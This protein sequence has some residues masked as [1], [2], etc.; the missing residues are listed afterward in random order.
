MVVSVASIDV[1]GPPRSVDAKP[2]L[3]ALLALVG[4]I[5]SFAIVAELS[6]SPISCERHKGAF[7]AQFSTAFDVDSVDCRAAWIKHSPTIHFWG[8]SPYVGVTW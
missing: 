8:G 3:L 4:L 7:S 1:I 5:L 6:Q 2:K